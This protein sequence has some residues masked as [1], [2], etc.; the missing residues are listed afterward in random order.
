MKLSVDKSRFV[1]DVIISSSR[2]DWCSL[3]LDLSGRPGLLGTAHQLCELGQVIC[4]FRT[5]LFVKR[6]SVN[7]VGFLM[8]SEQSA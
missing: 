8:N 2:N 3:E 4:P 1:S 6:V 7:S 5:C